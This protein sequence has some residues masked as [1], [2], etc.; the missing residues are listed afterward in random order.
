MAVSKAQYI[1]T[2]LILFIL[3]IDLTDICQHPCV[4]DSLPVDR[5][6]NLRRLP[7]RAVLHKLEH[8]LGLY[9]I[10]IL[11]HRIHLVENNIS[12]V[13]IHLPAPSGYKPILFQ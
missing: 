1:I 4:A 10:I 3:F 11:I 6:R 5:I 2:F 9:F 7:I 12:S 8:L 13:S